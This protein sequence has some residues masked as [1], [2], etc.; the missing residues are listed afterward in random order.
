VGAIAGVILLEGFLVTTLDT[1]IRLMRYS[2]EEI[3]QTL[4]AKFD[5]FATCD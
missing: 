5:V 2:L 3:W 1:A 4:F